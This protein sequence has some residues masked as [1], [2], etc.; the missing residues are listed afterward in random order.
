MLAD[1][2]A[3]IWPALPAFFLA[4]CCFVLG[5]II[6]LFFIHRHN[7]ATSRDLVLGDYV[8]KPHIPP[9]PIVPNRPIAA[10]YRR[11][12]S[13]T[14]VA[15]CIPGATRQVVQEV[16]EQQHA[17]P[18]S[19]AHRPPWGA[20]QYAGLVCPTCGGPFG[21]CSC[22]SQKGSTEETVV[23]PVIPP[24]ADLAP[25]FAALGRFF[26]AVDEARADTD[27]AMGRLVDDLAG[28]DD[29]PL[30]TVEIQ[31]EPV[32]PPEYRAATA[33]LGDTRELSS[34]MKKVSAP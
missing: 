34:V 16:Q 33:R 1:F 32:D 12:D 4:G 20:T 8:V 29:C 15:A 11:P 26:K 7:N 28:R 27:E 21:N 22:Y 23:L 24:A 14:G 6:W 18:D 2:L 19:D 25:Q 10:N 17:G 13:D 3:Y 30:T 31:I 5:G 9:A